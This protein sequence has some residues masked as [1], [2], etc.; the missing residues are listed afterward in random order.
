MALKQA[1][2][3]VVSAV[4]SASSGISSCCGNFR[5]R[6][7]MIVLAGSFRSDNVSPAARLVDLLER[8]KFNGFEVPVDI[9]ERTI[10]DVRWRQLL[11]IARRHRRLQ[12]VASGTR[13]SCRGTTSWR[14]G[15]VHCSG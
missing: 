1:S 5:V 9:R 13:A 14:T 4:V 10:P 2:C 15:W 6:A 8:A 7:M 12:G 11:R 3:D